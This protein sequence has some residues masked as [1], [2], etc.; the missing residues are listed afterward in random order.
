[1][2]ASVAT[3]GA[4]AGRA[5]KQIGFCWA[6]GTHS[7]WGTYAL[8]FAVQ[9]ARRGVSPAIFWSEKDLV[10]TEDQATAIGEAL[11][12]VSRWHAM[13]GQGPTTL[14]FPFLHALGDN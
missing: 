12:E 6:L 7:G 3:Q 9:C 10:L 11:K 8:N 1:M 4:H 5:S 14:D 13:L 2:T